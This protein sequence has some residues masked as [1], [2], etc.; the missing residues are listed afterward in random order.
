MQT[1]AAAKGRGV[2]RGFVLSDHADWRALLET[3]SATGAENIGVTHG[4]TREL[5]RYLEEERGLH[6]WV[7]PSRWE[8]D[9]AGEQSEE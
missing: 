8:A 7:M 2:D 1:R 3:I 6:A 4:Y 5:V 9:A